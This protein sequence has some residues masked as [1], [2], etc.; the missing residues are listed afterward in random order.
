VQNYIIYALT[1]ASSDPIEALAAQ[2]AVDVKQKIWNQKRRMWCTAAFLHA[3]GRND[4]T[5]ALRPVFVH[6]DDNGVTRIV[7]ENE[8]RRILTLHCGDAEEYSNAMRRTLKDLLSGLAAR[9]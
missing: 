2:P 5:F 3:A 9:R 6:L 8:G 1:K 7:S 4:P